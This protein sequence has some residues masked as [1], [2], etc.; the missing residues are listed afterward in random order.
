M[1][2]IIITIIVNQR[3]FE[4]NFRRIQNLIYFLLSVVFKFLCC[5]LLFSLVLCSYICNYFTSFF[6][7]VLLA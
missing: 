4:I 7:T 6:I 2:T 5:N 1:N 3:E